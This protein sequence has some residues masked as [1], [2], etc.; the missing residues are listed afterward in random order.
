MQLTFYVSSAN[1]DFFETIQG[2]LSQLKRYNVQFDFFDDETAVLPEVSY[3][4]RIV[5][6]LNSIQTF[7]AE[8][9]ARLKKG[10]A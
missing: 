2:F 5:S 7:L 1:S 9:L 6:G 10:L 4:G 8:I 3:N